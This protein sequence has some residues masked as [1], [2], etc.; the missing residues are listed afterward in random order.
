MCSRRVAQEENNVYQKYM[1]P[2]TLPP[3]RS[4]LLPRRFL[5]LMSLPHV[6]RLPA[7]PA[8]LPLGLCAAIAL[9][10]TVVHAAATPAVEVLP[11]LLRLSAAPA[12]LPP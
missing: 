11:P 9:L 2:P 4:L 10:V 7:T 3:S 6:G 12:G 8:G 5:L 1:T